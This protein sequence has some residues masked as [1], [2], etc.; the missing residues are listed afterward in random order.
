MHVQL[1]SYN[2]DPEPLGIG[3]VSTVWAKAMKERGHEIEIVAAHPHY[4]KPEW[5]M[6]L[7]PYREVR[8]GIPV[9]RLPL[10][11]GRDTRRRRL[12]Q[13]ISFMAAQTAAVPFLGRPD[14]II[15]VSPSFPA[16]LP[17]MLATRA[18]R[19]PWYLWLQDILPD[20]AAT[21]GLVDTGG[22]IYRGSR[23]LESAAYGSAAGIVVLSESFRE[24]L[25]SKGVPDSKIS[26]AF[27]P[28]TFPVESLYAAS[29]DREPPRIVCMG[30]IGRSQ[31]LDE[32]VRDFESDPELSK[33]GARLVICG[34]GVAAPEV[35]AAIRTDRVEMPGLLSPEDLRSELERASLAL[36][37]QAYGEGEFNVPSKLMNYLA[38][39]LPVIASVRPESEAARI[40][41]AS[42]A[43]WVTPQGRIGA[44]A[45]SALADPES[46][47]TKSRNGLSF[48]ESNLT[49]AALAEKFDLLLRG[50]T[51]PA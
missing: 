4:P 27:N 25:R 44:A 32:I 34:S 35:K 24:N 42:S 49:P 51:R 37:S 46:L 15:S 38:A 19:I 12:L 39:G 17:A 2:Y 22:M 7:K 1:W 8:D 50:G 29:A 5:G 45:S 3:P 6:K 41:E 23:R 18:R 40:V 36:V 10:L 21:T 11:I 26:V 28:A 9:T 48:A 13:E 16:L 47:R 14:T 30:N 43:G 31:G 20:G 33:L